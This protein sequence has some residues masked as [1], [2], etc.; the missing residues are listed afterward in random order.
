MPSEKLERINK[1]IEALE[2][3]K[4]AVKGTECEV[5]ARI[6]GYYR[7]IK[8]W[9][10]GKQAEYKQRKAYKIKDDNCEKKC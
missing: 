4:K 2:Q 1:D 9:N 5:Y 8:N 6:T 7:S 3:E 10:K